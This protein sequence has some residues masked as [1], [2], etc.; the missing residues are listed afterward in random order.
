MDADLSPINAAD[1]GRRRRPSNRQPIKHAGT[2]TT[3]S[4]PSDRPTDG[5]DRSP[6]FAGLIN[7]SHCT[8][9]DGSTVAF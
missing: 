4:P 7:Y 1:D 9:K 8:S 2:K 3:P 5:H 6:P